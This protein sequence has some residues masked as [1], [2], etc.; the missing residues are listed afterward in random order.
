MTGNLRKLVVIQ[1]LQVGRSSSL[2]NTVF[3]A[4]LPGLIMSV[5]DGVSLWVIV[6]ALAANYLL[7]NSMN[8]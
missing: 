7:E 5:V 8:M 1:G 4:A 3:T 6:Q 2:G